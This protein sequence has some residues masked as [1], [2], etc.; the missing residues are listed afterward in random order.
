[1][2]RVGPSYTDRILSIRINEDGHVQIVSTLGVPGDS[3][4]VFFI[5]FFPFLS[6]SLSLSL[7]LLFFFLS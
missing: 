6:L 1:M 4:K 3:L 7:S 2:L 5:F